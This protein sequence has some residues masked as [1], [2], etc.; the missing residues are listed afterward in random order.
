M[1]TLGQVGFEGVV[2][3]DKQDREPS[4]QLEYGGKVAKGVVKLFALF[5]TGQHQLG[6]A[7]IVF[8]LQIKNGPQYI[9]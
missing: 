5:G 1:N 8:Q 3:A 4:D 9:V 2:A 7:D 6:I